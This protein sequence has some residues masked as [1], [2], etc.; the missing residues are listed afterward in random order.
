M[1]PQSTFLGEKK[2]KQ[3]PLCA[4]GPESFTCLLQLLSIFIFQ[5]WTLNFCYY[6][7]FSFSNTPRVFWSSLRLFKMGCN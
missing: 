6:L 7:L 5:K 3:Q 1:N 2:K 4:A